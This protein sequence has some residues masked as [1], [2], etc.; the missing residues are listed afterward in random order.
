MQIREPLFFLWKKAVSFAQRMPKTLNLRR[1]LKAS[2]SKWALFILPWI[3]FNYPSVL[4]ICRFV[5]NNEFK[6]LIKRG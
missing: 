1:L 6:D 4:N 2:G 5:P 3:I